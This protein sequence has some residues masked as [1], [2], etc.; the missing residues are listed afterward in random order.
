SRSPALT[1]VGSPVGPTSSQGHRLILVMAL[2]GIGLVASVA[3]IRRLNLDWTP[4]KQV[5]RGA[6]IA[7]VVAVILLLLSPALLF[8]GY[9][10]AEH[11][12]A[13]TLSTRAPVGFSKGS[14]NLNDRLLQVSG[15]GRI[16]MWRAA[17]HQF[18]ANPVTGGGSGDFAAYWLRHRPTSIQVTQA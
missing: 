15:E 6:Q 3:V 16:E 8:A 11:S 4:S 10:S 13:D 2:G 9:S 14:A 7:G 17:W 18:S 5:I 1:H 12:V